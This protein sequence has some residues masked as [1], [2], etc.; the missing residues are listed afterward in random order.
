ML[1]GA[2]RRLVS[3]GEAFEVF[4]VAL[5]SGLLIFYFSKHALDDLEQCVVFDAVW[6]CPLSCCSQR[7]YRPHPGI[8]QLPDARVSK[9][10]VQTCCRVRHSGEG[11]VVVQPPS[12]AM[13][14]LVH[15]K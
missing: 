3:R 7:L 14:L 8:L 1:S 12:Q 5:Q 13:P 4:M 2:R 11:D 10:G 9:Q 6:P 15:K